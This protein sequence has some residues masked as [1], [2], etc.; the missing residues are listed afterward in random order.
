MDLIR[1]YFELPTLPAS[2]LKLFTVDFFDKETSFH[3]WRPKKQQN[4]EVEEVFGRRAD[5]RTPDK[6]I[7]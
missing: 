4:E 5:N 6:Y 3:K 2:G 1:F 7:W